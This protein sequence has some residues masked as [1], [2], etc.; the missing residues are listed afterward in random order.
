MKV[1]TIYSIENDRGVSHWHTSP[2]RLDALLGVD[3][4]KKK[5]RTYIG[6]KE[7]NTI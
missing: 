6:N 3:I 5:K 4:I 1:I 2:L 7:P